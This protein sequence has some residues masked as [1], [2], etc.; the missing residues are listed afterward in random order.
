MSQAS[1]N[2][3]VQKDQKESRE[4]VT[5]RDIG[6][7]WYTYGTHMVTEIK[8][9]DV[10]AHGHDMLALRQ[11]YGRL[12]MAMRT[13]YEYQDRMI[14]SHSM[15]HGYLYKQLVEYCCGFLLSSLVNTQLMFLLD[16]P[17]V[18]FMACAA[19]GHQSSDCH[20]IQCKLCL[21]RVRV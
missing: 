15:D 5:S 8:E 14:H 20:N 16:I 10:R 4:G 13:E 17:S 1:H 21:T 11:M 18:R 7:L 3:R 12:V 9:Y 19:I 6:S 2:I